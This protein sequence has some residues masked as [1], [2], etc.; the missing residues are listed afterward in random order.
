MSELLGNNNS[1]GCTKWACLC[2][3]IVSKV[4]YERRW[5]TH[6]IYESVKS[7]L[8]NLHF[9]FRRW[10]QVEIISKCFS[11]LFFALELFCDSA[12][13]DLRF[14]ITFECHQ[15]D[16]LITYYKAEWR[17]ADKWVENIFICVNFSYNNHVIIISIRSQTNLKIIRNYTMTDVTNNRKNSRQNGKRI[18]MNSIRMSGN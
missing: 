4:H 15:C 18:L 10:S 14:K 11:T 7:L 3:G 6:T 1:S 17:E 13:D 8:C 5:L 16:K 9:L 2:I 12:R